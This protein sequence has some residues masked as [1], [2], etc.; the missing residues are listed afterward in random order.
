MIPPP[1][2]WIAAVC[3]LTAPLQ[4]AAADVECGG[5]ALRRA[6]TAA[7]SSRGQLHALVIFARFQDESGPSSVPAFAG[8][9][10]DPAMPGSLTHFF[11]E[12][13]SGQFSMTGEVLPR[14]YVSAGPAARYLSDS[15][16]GRGDFGR[17]TREILNAADFDIDFGRFDNDG[18]DGIPNSGDDDGFV[19]LVIEGDRAIG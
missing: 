18:P 3:L 1:R 9:L 14:I 15:D 17:F 19:G 8:Q 16:T 10:F 5:L 11:D 2:N 6:A 7:L 12:M 13:S 4:A